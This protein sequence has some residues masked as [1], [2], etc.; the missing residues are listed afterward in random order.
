MKVL[1]IHCDYFSFAITE[2]TKFAEM[3]DVCKSCGIRDALVV[4]TTVEKRDEE[5]VEGV[6]EKG[7]KEVITGAKR[8]GANKLVVYPFVHLSSETAKPEI[9]KT[10]IDKF[11]KK[12]AGAGYEVVKA[13]FGWEKVFSL[14]SK[15]HPLSESFKTVAP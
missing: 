15:G 2:K 12:L 14:T 9:A 7:I 4:F 1:L 10:I 8:I 3:E 5:N 13:P 11:H 6:V